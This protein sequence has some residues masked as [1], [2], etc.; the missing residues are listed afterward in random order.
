MTILLIFILPIVHGNVFKFERNL[1]SSFPGKIL[2]N[3]VMHEF[4]S[5]FQISQ[6]AME[7]ARTPGCKSL[8][9]DKK[10]KL[11]HLN[12][13]THTEYPAD[14]KDESKGESVDYHLSDAFTIDKVRVYTHLFHN[15]RIW[16][17]RKHRRTYHKNNVIR[18]KNY[19]HAHISRPII[20][21]FIL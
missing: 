15:L 8:N 6:C 1:N 21:N 18:R 9:F 19:T 13:A 5:K 2:R 17:N 11:C 12:N 4:R 20:I 14:F 7:C 16:Q 3:H 10:H